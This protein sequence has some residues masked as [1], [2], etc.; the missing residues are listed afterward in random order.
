[1][2]IVSREAQ[3]CEQVRLRASQLRDRTAVH[4]RPPRGWPRAGHEP[5]AKTARWDRRAARCPQEKRGVSAVLAGMVRA[6]A[7]IANV[8]WCRN[9]GITK[10]RRSGFGCRA[11]SG[12]LLSKRRSASLAKKNNSPTAWP[13][14]QVL[15]TRSLSGSCGLSYAYK[16][17]A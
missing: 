17:S 14:R 2:R 6:R 9:G 13:S 16:G 7:S 15:Q 12:K 1:M 11:V 8:D 5:S 4:V 3:A 10:D